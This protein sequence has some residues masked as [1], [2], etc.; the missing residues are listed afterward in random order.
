MWEAVHLEEAVCI[1]M[2]FVT[3][4]QSH[5]PQRERK[6]RWGARVLGPA[7]QETD[8]ATDIWTQEVFEECS[9]ADAWGK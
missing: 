8:P 7:P 4:C 1:R 3:Y 9:G 2:A 6:E 5:L